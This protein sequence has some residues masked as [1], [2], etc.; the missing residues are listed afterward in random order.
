MSCVNLQL[1]RDGWVILKIEAGARGRMQPHKLQ[2]CIRKD[3]I[4][5]SLPDFRDFVCS[6]FPKQSFLTCI[7]FANQNIYSLINSL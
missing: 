1:R 2:C 3:S 4:K 7:S 5:P 6:L